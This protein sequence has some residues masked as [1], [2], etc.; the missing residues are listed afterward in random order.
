MKAF[1]A[2]MLFRWL[3]VLG[4]H[5]TAFLASAQDEDVIRLQIFLDNRHFGC[6]QID[7]KFGG[8]TEK[9][10]AFFNLQNGFAQRDRASAAAMAAREVPIVYASHRVLAQDFGYVGKVAG[11]I[12]AQAKQRGLPYASMLEF[13][14]ERYH[15]SETLIQKLNPRIKFSRL[16]ADDLVIVPY[17]RHVFRIESIP[18]SHRYTAEPNKSACYA[19]INTK[20]RMASFY[21]G[22][23]IL[24]AFPI[25]HGRA[26]FVPKGRWK[27]VN[28]V[29]TP[30]FRWDER[31]L[32]EGQ[33]SDHYY[34]LPPG[35][36]NPVGILWAGI[37]KKGI[38]LHGTNHPH[39]IGRTH[40]AG[41]IR[42]AN[43]DA[44]R[45]PTFLRPG[46]EVIVK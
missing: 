44:I 35:P 30:T 39:T 5:V 45:I 1:S 15:A 9:A 11:S 34:T 7:G 28:M 2:H 26:R 36:N 13:I 21:S 31:M 12:A 27:I 40:S 19:F 37:N 6:G 43:W 10:L 29:T 8:F 42:F 25:T 41:C 16:R 14:A 38:G 20:E 23:R 24:A 46:S 33:R 32:K 3:T 4:L 18:H 22:T 17:V